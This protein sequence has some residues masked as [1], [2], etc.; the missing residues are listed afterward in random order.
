S[1]AADRERRLR[2]SSTCREWKLDG[3]QPATQ[4]ADRRRQIVGLEHG[5]PGDKDVGAKLSDRP[6]ILK[7]HP[8]VDPNQQV[9]C[10]DQLPR[11]AHAIGGGWAERL[12]RQTWSDGEHEDQFHLVEKRLEY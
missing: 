2:T 3:R 5:A 8:T 1:G 9:T 6:D 7:R 10:T 11:F 4:R 12:P